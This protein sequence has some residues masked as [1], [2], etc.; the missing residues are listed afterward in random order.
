MVA[1]REWQSNDSISALFERLT[2]CHHW[3]YYCYFSFESFCLSISYHILMI[4]VIKC[5]GKKG[6]SISSDQNRVLLHYIIQARA[7]RGVCDK[8]LFAWCRHYLFLHDPGV[9]VITGSLTGVKQVVVIIAVYCMVT[10]TRMNKD[11]IDRKKKPDFTICDQ[12]K[13]TITEMTQE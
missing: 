2:S 13:I 1:V 10:L 6:F 4:S 9:I 3:W 5:L 11:W 7:L 8:K 12:N